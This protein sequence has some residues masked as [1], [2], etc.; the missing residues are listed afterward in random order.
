MK[1]LN[2]C[3]DIKDIAQLLHVI[4]NDWHIIN[5]NPYKRLHLITKYIIS[6]EGRD[7]D[8]LTDTERARLTSDIIKSRGIIGKLLDIIYKDIKVSIN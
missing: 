4:V 7:T 8:V 6:L 2:L 3:L 5:D 1:N